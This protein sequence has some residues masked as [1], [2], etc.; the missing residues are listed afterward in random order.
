MI[1]PTRL[2]SGSVGSSASTWIAAVLIVPSSAIAVRR[3]SG[4]VLRLPSRPPSI[5]SAVTG[6]M[7]A[8]F[9]RCATS[10]RRA[11]AAEVEVQRLARLRVLREDLQVRLDDA[12]Q[13][14]GTRGPAPPPRPSPQPGPTSSTTPKMKE[15]TSSLPSK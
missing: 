12:R 13:P 6:A 10:G 5:R 7:N 4:S 14:F 3:G 1:T 9:E 8:A 11:G 15:S 2:S